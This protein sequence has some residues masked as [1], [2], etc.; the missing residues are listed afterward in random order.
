MVP[1]GGPKRSSKQDV[2]LAHQP[3]TRQAQLI[4]PF[5]CQ[6]LV[7]RHLTTALRHS[8]H[9]TINLFPAY[10]AVDSASTQGS[11]VDIWTGR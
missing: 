8:L 6:N 5:L 9:C 3:G 11:E 2:F 10:L 1:Y 4:G 7:C